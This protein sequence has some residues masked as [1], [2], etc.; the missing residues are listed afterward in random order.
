[1]NYRVAICDD[2][3][4]Q[5]EILNDYIENFSFK[6]NY[7]IKIINAYDGE[8]LLGK[9]SGRGRSIDIKD[10]DIFLLDIEMNGMSGID[11][12]KKIKEKNESAAIIYITGFKDY[13]LYA[14][15]IRAF[16]YIMKPITY[17]MFAMLLNEVIEDLRC[18]SLRKEIDKI[19]LV[20]NK[21]QTLKIPY[22][23]IFYFEKYLRKTILTCRNEVIEFYASFK[24]L[25]KELDM[26]HFTQ[27]H[28]SFIVNNNKIYSYKNKEIYIK[29]LDKFIPVSKACVKEVKKV[30]SDELFG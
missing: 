30:L 23:Q 14:F 11:L 2:D 20:K 15:Q 4:S 21:R 5:V 17:K 6:T 1:M 25:K 27:C 3:R 16:H 18:K 8:E 28:Q 26:S 9:L 12:A 22:S 24:N 29:E 7:D 13:A 10:V 19:F